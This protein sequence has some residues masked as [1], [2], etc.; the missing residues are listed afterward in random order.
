MDAIDMEIERGE[1]VGLVGESGCGKSTLG[2]I[3]AGVFNR[4]RGSQSA[5]HVR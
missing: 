2:R 3:L 1:V 5:V 4:Q